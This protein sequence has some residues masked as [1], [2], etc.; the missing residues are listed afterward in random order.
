MSSFGREGRRRAYGICMRC[1]YLSVYDLCEN[2]VLYVDIDIDTVDAMM[3]G[4]M[5]A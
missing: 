3:F 1:G 5:H 4:V 2:V